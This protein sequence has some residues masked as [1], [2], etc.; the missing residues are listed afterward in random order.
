MNSFA[1]SY[2]PELP[3]SERRDELL[4]AIEENQVLIVAGETGSG[5]STQLPKMLLELGYGTEKLIGHTQPRRIAARTIAARIAEETNTAIGDVVGYTVRFTDKITSG[6]RLRLMTDGILLAELGRDKNLNRYDA[7]VIDEAHE[8]SLNIDF[9]LG[10]LK[11]LLPR[12]PDLKIIVTSAT[13]D[14]ERFSAHFDNAPVIQV[15]GRAFPVEVRYRPLEGPDVLEPRDETDG[16]VDAVEELWRDHPGDILVFCS[17]EREIRDATEAVKALKLRNSEVLP[18]YARLSASEQQRVFAS[19]NK[20]R[21]VI[22]TNVAETSVT[23]PGVRSVID[24]GTAR[25]SRYSHRTKV[26][27]LPIEA[28]SQASANQRSGRC[29]RLGPGV[30]IRLYAEDDFDSRDEFTEP[31]IQ[32]TNLASV[33]LQ[34]ASLSLG[35]I[36]EFGFVDPPEAR[37]IRDGIELLNELDAVRPEKKEGTRRW[38]SSLGSQLARLPV[39]PRYGRML[40]EADVNGPVAEVMI[41]VAGLSVQDPRERPSEKRQ[42]ADEFHKRYS[43]ERSDFLS[44][45]HLWDYLDEA[46]KSHSRNQFRRMCRRE[47]LNYNR[48]V[49]WQDIHRQLRQVARDLKLQRRSNQPR[50]AAGTRRDIDAA[51]SDAIHQSI[52]AGLLSHIGTKPSNEPS[53]KQGS[54]KQRGGRRKPS[55]YL[56]ARNARFAIAP[57]SVLFSDSPKWV[58][59]AE[60]VETSRLWARQVAQIDPGWVERIGEHLAVYSYGDPWWDSDGARAMV[61]ERVMLYG[62]T[63]TANRPV[64]VNRVDE[65]LARE[66][67][68]HHALVEGDWNTNHK[69]FDRNR[70]RIAEVRALEDRSRRRDL[71]VDAQA[72]HGFY[73]Q[74]IPDDVAT[75]AHF[76]SWWRKHQKEEPT[77]LD[78]TIAD[79]VDHTE[80]ELLDSSAFPD[81]W[82]PD[83]LDLELTYEFDPTSHLD[84]LSVLVPVDVMNQLESGEFQWLV[85]GLRTELVTSLVRSLPKI[86]R[87]ELLPI[88]E[89]VDAALAA[90]DPSQGPLFEVLAS[91]LGKRAGLVIPADSFDVDRLRGHLRPT[92]RIINDSYE[93][94]AE[95]KD[96]D[97]LKTRLVDDVRSSL[98]VAAGDLSDGSAEWNQP[99]LTS[100]SVGTIP[101]LVETGR[102]KAHPAL[103]DEGNSVALRLFATEDEQLDAHWLGVRR[104]VRFSI[105]SPLRQLDRL[106]DQQTKLLL[107]NGEVQSKS[108]WYTDTIDCALDEV[109]ASYACGLPWNEAAWDGLVA[110]ADDSFAEL[111][112][113][114]A[115]HMGALLDVLGQIRTRIDQHRSPSFAASIDDIE[116]H[117]ARLAY[118]GFMTGVGYPRLGDIHRYLSAVLYRVDG[119]ARNPNRDAEIAASFRRLDSDLAVVT[120]QSPGAPEVEEITWMMEEL[121]VSL[122]AQRLG[123]KGKVSEKRVLRALNALKG[124][125]VGVR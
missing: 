25:I 125:I 118:P 103:V 108:E 12:R 115:G 119:V 40:L 35:P 3:I 52:L 69:F 107:I 48:I 7:I 110:Y 116:S 14:T 63:L 85:P 31:E 32:R 124:P 44:F 39:D 78:L 75:A 73:D 92:F 60:L 96:L 46:R 2:P 68:I 91:Q 117:L 1:I 20:R 47:F 98:S 22:A 86:V 58:M 45:I 55:E 101:R 24:V 41:I 72:I 70:E 6:T 33:I 43:D 90:V 77:L 19:H 49:E 66:M 67:F 27:R 89:T 121:R 65:K 17:G 59:A 62:L 53:K 114:A 105:P 4:A 99:D 10:Y 79:L 88:K 80:D 106:L 42:A 109:I 34:M 104:L 95:G 82:D 111:L 71:L 120:S 87:R 5:K 54:D 97:G 61:A 122:F 83:G 36:D 23:V 38:L 30:A 9:I 64:P 29:G 56:G 51:A 13:I 21:V 50:I 84:G 93:L 102:V 28:I 112:E 76:N 18:L 11:R 74:R 57:G 113:G 15:S 100:W 26:Q 37:S 123:A 8:R 94:L 81:A 16:I